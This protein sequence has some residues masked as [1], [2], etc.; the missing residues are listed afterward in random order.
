MNRQIAQAVRIGVVV[1]TPFDAANVQPASVT[2]TLGAD[3]TAPDGKTIY[4]GRGQSFTLR[5]NHTINVRTKER[6][7]LPHDYVGRVGALASLATRG[8][9]TSAGFQIAPGF[10]GCLELSLFNSGQK[11]FTLQTGMP[12]ISLE[13]IV[14]D[15]LPTI[16]DAAF[17]RPRR[18]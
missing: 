17:N 6:I 8:I 4:L 5:R 3:L 14:L 16:D 12:V 15:T 1:I 10:S 13:I 7:E 18:R 2:L 11:G 9:V